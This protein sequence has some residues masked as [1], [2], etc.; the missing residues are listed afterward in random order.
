MVVVVPFPGVLMPPGLLV[1]TQ[2]PDAGSP[3]NGTLPVEVRH[4]GWIMIPIIG[5][6]G[7]GFNV[8]ASVRAVLVPQA[9]V[10]V[11]DSVPEVAAAE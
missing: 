10:A 9:L 5:A 7:N 6:E 3:L 4:P 1:I 11:T 8:I 2:S